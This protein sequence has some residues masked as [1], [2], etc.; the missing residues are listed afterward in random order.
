MAKWPIFQGDYDGAHSLY[1]RSLA[2][3]DGLGD[4]IGIARCLDGPGGSDDGCEQI[5]AYRN[6]P[7]APRAAN[8]AEGQKTGDEGLQVSAARLLGHSSGVAREHWGFNLIRKI[9]GCSTAI[10]CGSTCSTG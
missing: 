4:K 2:L 10:R 7:S 8:G 1:K 6:E 5:A 9:A 3:S